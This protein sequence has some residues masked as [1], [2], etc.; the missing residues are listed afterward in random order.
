[1]N[2]EPVHRHCRQGKFPCLSR[3]CCKPQAF[4]YDPEG[5]R[6]EGIKPNFPLEIGV[7]GK[8]GFTKK[9]LVGRTYAG[10][11]GYCP[12]ADY[13]GSLGYCLELAL[14]PGVQHSA[15]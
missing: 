14:R 9:E 10:V 4:S 7:N 2:L 6:L 12:F 8:F 5:P 3:Q 11:E 15:V 1:M 13:L